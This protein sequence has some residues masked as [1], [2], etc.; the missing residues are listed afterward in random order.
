MSRLNP[1]SNSHAQR[2]PR[3]RA[4]PLRQHLEVV[5]S[6]GVQRRAL[7]VVGRDAGVLDGPRDRRLSLRHLPRP[8][9][10]VRT[11]SGKG[12]RVSPNPRTQIGERA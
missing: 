2:R 6:L 4:V 5:R 3:L 1:A 9:V 7:A 10:K 11:F 8:F 12:A